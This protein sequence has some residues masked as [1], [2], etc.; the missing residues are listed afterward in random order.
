MKTLPRASRSASIPLLC[1]IALFSIMGST[2]GF[3]ESSP[4]G[5]VR[6][7]R[8][9]LG[10][11]VPFTSQDDLTD[12]LRQRFR[13]G[14]PR[15]DINRFIESICE[16]TLPI[17]DTLIVE[18]KTSMTTITLGRV[19]SIEYPEALLEIRFEFDG[20]ER[21]TFVGWSA[22]SRSYHPI[23]NHR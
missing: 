19:V 18:Y 3:G 20:E 9:L 21:L 23:E 13:A 8:D 12:S 17:N 22:G 1:F 15:D 5:V 6:M 14:S 11:K 7:G 16:R 2:Y 4:L 10:D